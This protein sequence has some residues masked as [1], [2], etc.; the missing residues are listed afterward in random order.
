MFRRVGFFGRNYYNSD[1]DHKYL[2]PTLIRSTPQAEGE[3]MMTW[4]CSTFFDAG[5]L[6]RFHD[7]LNPDIYLNTLNDY[8]LGTFAWFGMG[9]TGPIFSRTIL[10]CMQP[11][12]CRGGSRSRSP[13]YQLATKFYIPQHH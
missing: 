7:A 10:E 5:S 13:L 9:P 2:L 11:M 1:H 12:H 3:I 6:C 8:V 4:C